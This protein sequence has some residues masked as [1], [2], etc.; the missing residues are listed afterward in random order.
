MQDYDVDNGFNDINVCFLITAT[1]IATNETEISDE[2]LNRMLLEGGDI[3][4]LN[5][6]SNISPFRTVL[7]P[8]SVKIMNAFIKLIDD[9]EAR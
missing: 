5:N 9:N 6:T 4:E 7:F 2:D 8:N 1:P 3:S